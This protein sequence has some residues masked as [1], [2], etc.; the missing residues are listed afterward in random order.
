M[1]A[2]FFDIAF[3]IPS[4]LLPYKNWYVKET[5]RWSW[6]C[7]RPSFKQKQKYKSK[8]IFP[9]PWYDQMKWLKEHWKGNFKRLERCE[10][11]QF[12][13]WWMWQIK[14]IFF[15]F[16]LS[17]LRCSN[18]SVLLIY[19]PLCLRLL[20][21]CCYSFVFFEDLDLW[22]PGSSILSFLCL[23]VCVCVCGLLIVWA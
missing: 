4:Y 20:F 11:C 21:S 17:F 12:S 7:S 13:Q 3:F 1:W 14:L 16:A 22:L 5:S 2:C 10:M 15:F 6:K 9:K 19:L 8:F 23:R 18:C